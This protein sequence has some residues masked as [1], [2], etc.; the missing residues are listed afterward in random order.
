ML[1]EI[2]HEPTPLCFPLAPEGRHWQHED[3]DVF[4][5]ERD[6]GRSLV[7]VRLRDHHPPHRIG[8]VRLQGQFL[9]QACQPPF[10]ARRLA[11]NFDPSKFVRGVNGL[12]RRWR[13][14]I[15]WSNIL[16]IAWAILAAVLSVALIVI[17]VAF[18]G[19][20]PVTAPQ[21]II[22][23]F[24]LFGAIPI[25]LFS[26]GVLHVLARTNMWWI[27]REWKTSLEYMVAQPPRTI[28]AARQALQ[29]NPRH[30]RDRRSHA[31]GETE[32]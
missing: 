1:S 12:K 26:C 16:N 23:T 2:G 25:G 31:P 13:F 11:S 7:S 9:A 22:A 24:V 28:A 32:D 3:F 15:W 5:G 17:G 29:D 20:A 4:D 30:G 6:V 27:S 8:P 14:Y 18:Y 10:Q 21:A 19:K